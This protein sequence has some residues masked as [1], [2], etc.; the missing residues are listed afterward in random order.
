M[1][2]K[3]INKNKLVKS[4]DSDD[5]KLKDLYLRLIKQES[6]EDKEHK[7]TNKGFKLE[8]GKTSQRMVTYEQYKTCLSYYF[9]K[10]K[11][12]P[13]MIDLIPLTI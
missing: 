4:I 12:A 6:I 11:V 13:N 1:S 2:S 8:K 10:R 7:A 5:Q 9:D 3:G